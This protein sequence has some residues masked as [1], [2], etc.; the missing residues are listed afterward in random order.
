M[1]EES[2]VYQQFRERGGLADLSDRTKLLFTGA[3]R[4]RYLNG[5]VTA[6][7]SSL[8]TG[9][10]L[11]ACVTTAKGKLN[12][13]VTV[14]AQADA[15]LI[16][17]ASEL[18]EELGMRLEKYI[19]ADDVTL[20]DVTEERCLFHVF[21][22]GELNMPSIS[23]AEISKARRFGSPGYDVL[24]PIAARSEVAQTLAAQYGAL[25][26]ELLES[27]RIERGVPA[28]GHELT[29]NTLPP[30]AGLDRSHIDYHK[31]CYI[32]Q[33]VISR[34]KSVGHVNRELHGFVPLSEGDSLTA[35]M[36][37]FAPGATDRQIGELTSAAWSFALAKP[38]ALGYLR[39]GSP[40]DDLI[41]LPADADTPAV[42]VAARELPFTS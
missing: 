27:I 33:E 21:G 40:M 39:R 22:A 14:T 17:A 41:A 35:G 37:L 12:A 19:I 11:P 5:Q 13:D 25:S 2:L 9:E 20:S 32:G 23:G 4:V 15:I 36:R 3:D 30:E 26:P 34:L 7:V 24:A 10:S 6:N 18:R 28:W 38:I 1:S 8:K 16:D 29:P 42:H 31:G